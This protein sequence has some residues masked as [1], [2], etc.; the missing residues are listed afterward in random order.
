MFW[1]VRASHA[2]L[3]SAY[4][5]RTGWKRFARIF[6]SSLFF[7][8]FF[9]VL[10]IPWVYIFKNTFFL[11]KKKKEKKIIQ[12][13]SLKS[14]VWNWGK[15]SFLGKGF[16]GKFSWKTV[17]FKYFFQNLRIIFLSN[18]GEFFFLWWNRVKIICL[19]FEEWWKK[20]L[21]GYFFL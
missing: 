3:S 2:L 17:F 5:V 21:P 10:K 6:P 20:F 18:S 9:L 11:K 13:V 7:E 12:K 16:C 14:F 1:G 19:C 15:E 8:F 4:D